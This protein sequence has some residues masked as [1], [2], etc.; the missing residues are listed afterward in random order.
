MSICSEHNHSLRREKTQ[1]R[2]KNIGKRIGYFRIRR[3]RK[4]SVSCLRRRA[5]RSTLDERRSNLSAEKPARIRG[6]NGFKSERA[7]HLSG[8]R[9]DCG[10][11]EMQNHL[12]KRKM[13]GSSRDEL[14]GVLMPKGNFNAYV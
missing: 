3:Q 13:P 11:G 8:L 9:S 10:A 2:I 5:H 7:P 6:I 4:R 14:L 1:R 12:S